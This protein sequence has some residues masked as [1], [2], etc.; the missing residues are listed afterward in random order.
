MTPT[1]V[2]AGVL[3]VHEGS[4]LFLRRAEGDGRWGLP[5]GGIVGSETRIE[6]LTREVMEE[7]GL[8]LPGK[9]H[10]IWRMISNNG[11][12]DSDYTVYRL[13]VAERMTPTLDFEHD[14]WV[15]AK[16][17]DPPQPPHPSVK[18]MLATLKENA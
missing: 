11:D 7:T 17:D 2:S 3:F 8:T 9:P 6:G 5:G 15:W 12:H 18:A 10:A 16:L 4:A 14:D 1:H 13:D